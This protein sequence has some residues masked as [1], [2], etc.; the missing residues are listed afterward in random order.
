[1]KSIQPF[2]TTVLVSCI[3]FGVSAIPQHAWLPKPCPADPSLVSKCNMNVLV[4][5]TSVN[6]GRGDVTLKITGPDGC[7]QDCESTKSIP[8]T[9][10]YKPPCFDERG[11]MDLNVDGWGNVPTVVNWG[12]K[13]WNVSKVDEGNMNAEGTTQYNMPFNCTT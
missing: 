9:D 11:T 7:P 13:K 10:G 12:G 2:S 6:S 1:M 8:W 3:I 4:E 5:L